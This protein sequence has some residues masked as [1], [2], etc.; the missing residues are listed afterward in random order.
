VPLRY[1]FGPAAPD[2]TPDLADARAA[3]H[4][5][6][7]NGAGAD[8]TVGPDGT[9]DD[10]VARLPPGW[11]P[12]FIALDLAYATVPACLWEAPIPL[13]ALAHDWPLLWH[14]Y[15]R[16]LPR[17]ELA[18]ADPAGVAALA[19]QGLAHARPAHLDACT[20]AAPEALPP[21]GRRDIDILC[22]VD[23]NPATGR[24][25]LPWLARL[26][27]L[28]DRRRVVLRAGTADARALLAGP[29][30]PSTA[31]AAAPVRPTPS[32][33]PRP[34]PC[35]SCR[36]TTTSPPSAT[37]RSA[38]APTRTTWRRS[39]TTTSTTRTSAAPS[40][41]RPGATPSRAPAARRGRWRW[42]TWSGNG[43]ASGSGPAAAR[44]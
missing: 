2:H 37:A 34:A 22:V 28:A 27:D 10:L 19:R 14:H 42:S 44:R 17:C 36:P 5:L 31:A 7:V 26:A 41:P 32:R 1:L 12:D 39:S 18:L 16:C 15:R 38:S 21:E 35:C 13:V 30:S 43:P 29:A 6:L 8:L 25:Q 4:C 33:P 3:G 9:W 23:P 40:P 24:E 20:R 11:R